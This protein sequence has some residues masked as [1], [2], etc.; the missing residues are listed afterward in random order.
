MLQ[1]TS[2]PKS[3]KVVNVAKA[4]NSSRDSLSLGSWNTII[5]AQDEGKHDPITFMRNTKGKIAKR[6]SSITVASLDCVVLK[7]EVE[8]EA[9]QLLEDEKIENTHA[10]DNSTQKQPTVLPTTT[11]TITT[12]S[13][14]ANA[15]SQW[16]II[17][18]AKSVPSLEST[19]RVLAACNNVPRLPLLALREYYHHLSM[20]RNIFSSTV[21]SNS[22]DA[23]SIPAAVAS[24]D[25]SIQKLLLIAPKSLWLAFYKYNKSN[26]AV[27][28]HRI[29]RSLS[30]N[31]SPFNS[32]KKT[33]D[34]ASYKS[35]AKN[36]INR[37]RSLLGQTK[38]SLKVVSNK[39]KNIHV[40]VA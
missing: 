19:V 37:L 33:Y 27:Q 21:P 9:A 25:A 29:I 8:D 39:K 32:I 5:H 12:L 16:A 31:D 17:K 10:P 3:I 30:V 7:D 4:R 13:L 20:P 28:F 2:I 24:N 40:N 11:N 1:K 15:A 14:S 36:E 23:W 26:N 38:N 6:L 35:L 22:D 34:L 18:K